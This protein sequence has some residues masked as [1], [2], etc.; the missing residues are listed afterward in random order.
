MHAG[1]KSFRSLF[2][3]A[4]ITA[5]IAFAPKPAEAAPVYCSPCLFFGGNFNPSGS[6]SSALANEKDLVVS[7]SAI[8]TPFVVPGG[9]SWGISGLFTNNLMTTVPLSAAWEI[10][11]GI[12]TGNGG[13]V[14]FS[15][16]D[17]TPLFTD[18]GTSGLGITIYAV[19][20]TGLSGV[21]LGA[22]TYWLS[23]VPVCLDSSNPACNGRSFQASTDGLDAFGPPEPENASFWNSSSFDKDFTLINTANTGTLIDSTMSAGVIGTRG[24]TSVDEPSNVLATFGLGVLLIGMFAR[25]RR[26]TC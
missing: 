5:L 22:G 12:A 26:R 6:N 13:T 19:G 2:G 8:Y 15:G 16:T 11:S 17:D 25:R 23:V 9:Q 24:V 4:A 10:R 21:T 20:V 1:R 18:T 14:L 3:L 7:Q